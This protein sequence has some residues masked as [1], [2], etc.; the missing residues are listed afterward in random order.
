MSALPGTPAPAPVL[1]VVIPVFNEQHTLPR[2]VAEVTA[3]L[4]TLPW[5]WRVT[6]ADNAST[7]ATAEVA[8]RLAASYPGVRVLH[9]GQKGRGRALKAAWR[10]SDAAVLAYLDVDL[11]TDLAALLP[12]V[13]PLVSGHSDVAIGSRLDPSSVVV[14][15]PRREVISRSYNLILRG[16]LRVRFRDA[17]CGFKAVRADVARALLPLVEDDTWFFDTELLVLAERAG[18]RI[19][20]VPVDWVDD[21]D[22]RVDIVRTA[23]DDLAGVR[24][25]RHGLHTGAI[26]LDA[27]RQQ[28][29]RARRRAGVPAGALA[30]LAS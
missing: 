21:A 28:V 7:D 22:S 27:A 5:T 8:A 26:P 18:F 23:L 10:D 3:H 29:R 2:A 9:L 1:D 6:V 17:Q 16:A 24:R 20:E 19:H 13:A 14:R 4:A 15:G 11:S 30:R 25:L 12:L